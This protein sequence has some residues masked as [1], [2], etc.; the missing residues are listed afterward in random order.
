MSICLFSPHCSFLQVW[1]SSCV[2]VGLLQCYVALYGV[3]KLTITLG[4][5]Q[6]LAATRH[7]MKNSKLTAGLLEVLARKNT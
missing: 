1:L 4:A 7:V 2:L 6:S 3:F 5:N